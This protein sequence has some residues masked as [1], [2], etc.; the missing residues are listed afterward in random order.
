MTIRVILGIGILVLLTLDVLLTVF[1]PFGHGGPLHR[2][3]NRLQ[4]EVVRRLAGGRSGGVRE[5]TMGL[6]GPILTL[7]AVGG[8]AVA[9]VVGFAFLYAG[10]PGAF[11]GGGL[12]AL[13]PMAEALYYSGY[14]ATTLGL[15]DVIAAAPSARLLTVVEAVAGFALF[16]VATTYVL[17]ISRELSRVHAVALQLAVYRRWVADGGRAAAGKGRLDPLTGM[18]AGLPTQFLRIALAHGQ[19]PL[20][21]FFRPTDRTRD[22]AAQLDWLV[23]Q[24]SAAS[25]EAGSADRVSDEADMLRVAVCHFLVEVNRS[26]IPSWFRPLEEGLEGSSLGALHDRL[27]RYVGRPRESG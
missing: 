24:L 27:S 15:G 21:Q 26:C 13:P 22:L 4:W 12:T 25:V 6:A 8:W 1:P 17:A 20:I 7:V 18:A 11:V 14:V 23:P 2:R 9:L 3:L 5:R 19:Y 10:I 16:A